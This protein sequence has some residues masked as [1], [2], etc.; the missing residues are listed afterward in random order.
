MLKI[1]VDFF[2]N[3]GVVEL[4]RFDTELF[5]IMLPGKLIMIALACLFIYLGVKKG[6][7]PY[8]LDRKSVV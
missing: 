2:Q 8:L 4:F 5:G 7:E 3:S 6:Y 1:L